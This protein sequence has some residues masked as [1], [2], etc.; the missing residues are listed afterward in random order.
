MQ[1]SRRKSFGEANAQPAF[2]PHLRDYG[3]AGAERPTR[4]RRGRAP[5]WRA[6]NAEVAEVR[7]ESRSLGEGSI[8]KGK[9]KSRLGFRFDAFDARELVEVAIERGN[10][11]GFGSGDCSVVGIHKVHIGLREISQ[12][13]H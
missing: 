3:A 6:L 7:V 2:V 10:R 9:L 1:E 11:N 13:V 12:R 5:P 8:K 4:L